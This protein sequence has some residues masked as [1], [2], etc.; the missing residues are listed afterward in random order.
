VRSKRTTRP[1]QS[2]GGGEEKKKRRAGLHLDPLRLTGPP[3]GRD[4]R[5][6]G[7]KKKRDKEKR[8]GERAS[9]RNIGSSY[10][11]AVKRV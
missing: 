5:E 6:G 10:I 9:S 11:G 2:K 7:E 3:I 8:G 4:A 1:R